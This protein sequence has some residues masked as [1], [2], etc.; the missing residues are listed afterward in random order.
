MVMNIIKASLQS[1]IQ[2][3]GTPTFVYSES[4]IIANVQRIAAAIHKSGIENKVKLYVSYFANS[5][6]HLAS[7]LESQGAGLTLQSLEENEHLKKFG[8][9]S[10]CKVLSLTHLSRNDL[11]YFIQE[12]IPI[13]CATLSNLETLLKSECNEPRIRIDLSPESNQRQGIK[14]G[15]FPEVKAILQKYGKKLYGIQMYAGTGNGLDVHTRYQTRGFEC[16]KYF[17]E[18]KEINLGG[19]FKF[20]Y[21]K[22]E[23]FGWG[24]YFRALKDRMNKYAL[25][26]KVII[27]IEPGRDVFADA[28]CLVLR[29]NGA[30]KAWG[31]EYYEVFTDG[32]Y[33]HMPSATMRA[34]QH[35]LQ[36]YDSSFNS[37]VEESHK[38]QAAQLS[39]N[40][41][42]SNDRLFPGIVYMPSS[43]KEDD[44][45]IVEDVGAY[46]ATQ[47][48]DFLNKAPAAEVL[49]RRNGD[50]ERIT[51]RG[52]F[53]DKTRYVLPSPQLIWR[54]NES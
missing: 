8:L 11:N 38:E 9:N 20:D 24:T 40:T 49:I 52:D 46:C 25:N 27:D 6:P 33:V 14:P 35:R 17:P 50:I 26:N 19:G 47:H 5:N 32:S 18:L 54:E 15:Q 7:I 23:H 42:L 43:L 12:K 13:N 21:E 31:K 2:A 28:G 34:R 44:Y 45:I 48:M 30:E 10:L 1:I 39:G 29:V 51:A 41:T 4:T 53:T 37:I 3:V 22:Q 16:L 36:F